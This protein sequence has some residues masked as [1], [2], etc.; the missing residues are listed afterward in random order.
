MDSKIALDPHG[1]PINDTDD[2]L[3]EG[4]LALQN[5]SYVNLEN[6]RLLASESQTEL[7]PTPAASA[8]HQ[9]CTAVLRQICIAQH[10]LSGTRSCS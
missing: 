2:D 7:P 5:G 10:L 8:R 6:E 3:A 1:N 9:V 4:A